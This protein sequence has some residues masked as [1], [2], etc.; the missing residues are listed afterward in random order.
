[1]IKNR[2]YNKLMN[3]ELKKTKQE[4]SIIFLTHCGPS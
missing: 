1:M 2:G 4:D 3:E